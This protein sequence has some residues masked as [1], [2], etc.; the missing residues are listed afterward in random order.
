MLSLYVLETIPLLEP[1][2]PGYGLDVLT[3]VE[4]I[5]E[6]PEL[7]LRKLDRLRDRDAHNR[8]TRYQRWRP[9]K[10]AKVICEEL[11]ALYERGDFWNQ[12]TITSEETGSYQRQADDI[13]EGCEPLIWPR[14]AQQ[15]RRRR[16]Q[17]PN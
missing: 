4:S 17:I 13:F 6:N 11:R 10:A 12:L 7:I 1:E 2:S 3:L 15:I 8:A 9:R 14:C 16:C 5:L